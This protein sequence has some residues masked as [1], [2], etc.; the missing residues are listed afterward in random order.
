[1]FNNLYFGI[2]KHILIMTVIIL[3]G[4]AIDQDPVGYN[5]SGTRNVYFHGPQSIVSILSILG[6]T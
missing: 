3:V 2:R 6:E 5:T 1:M 4:I